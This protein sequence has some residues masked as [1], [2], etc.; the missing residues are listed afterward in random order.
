MDRPEDIETNPVNRQGLH[1]HDQQHPARTPRTSRR[2]RAPTRARRTSAGH[3]I[4]ITEDGDDHAATTF[5]WDIFML[6]GDPADES[7]YFAGFPKDKVS[8]IASPDNITF[9]VDGQPLDLDRRPAEHAR[10]QRRPLR[11][12]G[13]WR[14]AR[15]PAAVLQRGDRRRGLRTDLH[16]GQH[17]PLRRRSSTRAKAAPSTSRPQA[18][19]K[20]AAHPGR[21]S[22]L[23]RRTTAV[24]SG[25]NFPHNNLKQLSH[26]PLSEGRGVFLAAFLSGQVAVGSSLGRLGATETTS[27]PGHSFIT[28][29]NGRHVK[30]A[31]PAANPLP[32]QPRC[33]EPCPEPHAPRP[34]RAKGGGR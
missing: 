5:A 2:R 14:G 10:G 6:C 16:S 13:R 20:P 34:A 4:E 30:P 15:L 23:S 11:G 29:D 22:L 31:T 8:P 25:R 24:R 32:P 26:S 12:A 1:R 17:R 3:I 7:T 27:I 19:P 33:P 21:Q 28:F 18:G 9:D